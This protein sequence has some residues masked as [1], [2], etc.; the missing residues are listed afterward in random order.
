[1]NPAIRS[2]TPTLME[3][4]TVAWRG[5]FTKPWLDALERACDALALEQAR[6]NSGPS[7]IRT[8]KVAWV[9]RDAA[10]EELYRD[11]EAI[12]L[13]LNAE[14]FHFDLA[15]LATMQYAVYESAEAGF[16]DWHNDYGRYRDDPGQLPRK[17]TMSVQLSEGAGYD[18]GDL[19]VRA[20]HPIDMA[21][22][23]RGCLVAF[24]ANA[25]HRVTPV[26]RGV[27]KS[28]VIWAT[29]PEFR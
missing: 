7:S 15:G 8:T 24:A 27:R 28:L 12:V 6:L 18:G 19:E 20:I 23:E 21:P 1:M 13:R 29:G 5:L 2:T 3:G 11:M 26:T 9:H 16:F 17:I 4:G 10:T 22:R 25:L 14:L